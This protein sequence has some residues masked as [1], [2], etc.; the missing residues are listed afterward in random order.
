MY[1]FFDSTVVETVY[2]LL[3]YGSSEFQLHREAR[4]EFHLQ[5]ASGENL[6]LQE[7]GRLRLDAS[8]RHHLDRC[9]IFRNNFKPL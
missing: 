8:P 6:L 5:H 3:L 1:V 4:N 7:V 2:V 9:T